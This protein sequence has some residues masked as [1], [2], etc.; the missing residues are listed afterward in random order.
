MLWSGSKLDH[1]GLDVTRILVDLK[2]HLILSLSLISLVP[3]TFFSYEQV[4]GNGLRVPFLFN[5]RKFVTQKREKPG[6]RPQVELRVCE[7]ERDARAMKPRRIY[8]F[9][10]YL[11]S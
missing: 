11:C 6:S 5:D 4:P 8:M 7:A 9:N 10:S 2:P 3:S 1:N